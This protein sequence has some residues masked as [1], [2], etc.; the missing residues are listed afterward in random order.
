MKLLLVNFLIL[1][2]LFQAHAQEAT[3]KQF[4]LG[5]G[6][7]YAAGTGKGAKGGFLLDAEPGYVLSNSFL[8]NVRLQTAAILRGATSFQLQDPNL[9]LQLSKVG[10]T[11]INGQY[12]LKDAGARPYVGFGAGVYSLSAVQFKTDVSGVNGDVAP[13]QR[14]FGVYPRVGVDLGHFN[15]NLD[16][17]I[18]PQTIGANGLKFRNSYAA[19]RLSFFIGGGRNILEEL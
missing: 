6:A 7:G 14:K 10:S 5:L 13:R 19:F 12:Y 3:L 16:Y 9:Q 18:I 17:N 2:A 8:I 15:I 1:S 4:R 11:T